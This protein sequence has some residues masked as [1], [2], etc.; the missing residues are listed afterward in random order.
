MPCR[1]DN[2]R[3]S[4]LTQLWA[5]SKDTNGCR[6]PKRCHHKALNQQIFHHNLCRSRPFL[7]YY[8]SPRTCPMVA[9][10]TT[11][12]YRQGVP[13]WQYDSTWSHSAEEKVLQAYSS[14][15]QPS[16]FRSTYAPT[17]SD[18]NHVFFHKTRPY[19]PQAYSHSH[20]QVPHSAQFKA[21]FKTKP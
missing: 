6:C 9:L 2:L 4:G 5:N 19:F 14:C 17:Q 12:G 11:S 21:A 18:W 15:M 7:T 3:P 8:L 13:K 1:W 10:P 20:L 16:R